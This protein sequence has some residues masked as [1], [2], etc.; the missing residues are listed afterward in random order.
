MA[1]NLPGLEA[2]LLATRQNTNNVPSVAGQKTATAIANFWTTGQGPGGA[3]VIGAPTGPIMAPGIIGAYSTHA[4]AVIN[5]K[6]VATAIDTAALSLILAGGVY[7]AHIAVITP[8]PSGLASGL[9][10]IWESHPAVPALAA[11]KE[12]KEI[13]NYTSQ[14]VANGTGIPAV[15]IPPQVGPIV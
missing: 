5:A 13:K 10:R 7:G 1:L 6:K 2:E 11:K 15:P 3:S 12:A 9:Q 8:G 14:L 4:L